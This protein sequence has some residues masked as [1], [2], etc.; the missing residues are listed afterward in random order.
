MEN[1]RKLK[2]KEVRITSDAEWLDIEDLEGMPSFGFKMP[3]PVKNDERIQVVG[4]SKKN[5]RVKELF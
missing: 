1:K 4:P 2:P 3:S 5:S